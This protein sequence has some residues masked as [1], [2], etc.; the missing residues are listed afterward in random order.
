MKDKKRTSVFLIVVIVVFL[1]AATVYYFMAPSED[2][3]RGGLVGDAVC[4]N[5]GSEEG[6]DLCCTNAHADD[7]L[8]VSCIG[9]WKYFVDENECRFVCELGCQEDMRVCDDGSSVVRDP[10]NGCEFIECPDAS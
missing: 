1:V 5:I 7:E 8:K 6:R 2:Y 4:G 9:G 10:E 3:R